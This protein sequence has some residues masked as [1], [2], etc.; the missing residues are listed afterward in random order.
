MRNILLF[1]LLI[2][3]VH[4][5]FSQTFEY[6]YI[7]NNGQIYQIS[8]N[9]F[10]YGILDDSLKQ[11]KVYSLD[12]TLM[13]TISLL[14]DSADGNSIA[15][16]NL[17]RTLFNSDDN[18]ELLYNWWDWGGGTY[19]L[20]I[21]IL[22]DNGSVVFSKDSAFTV[23]LYNTPEGSKLLVEY[24]TPYE[25]RR[26]VTVYSLYGVVLESGE[27]GSNSTCTLF[28]NPTKG[29]IEIH[30]STPKNE[31]ALILSI[32]TMKGQSLKEINMPS[33]EH[34]F[35]LNV[36]EFAPGTYFLRIHNNNFSTSVQQFIIHQ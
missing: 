33:N 17:S 30:Y 34:V 29:N 35:K 26:N 20:G 18:L 15:I 32:F 31:E 3:N 8:P 27:I 2:Q 4:F 36:S 12:H 21:K 7:G 24:D 16:Y 23:G 11:F 9:E 10:V 14:P 13:N 28:P 19:H 5:T 1:I 25:Y 6:Q 22:N